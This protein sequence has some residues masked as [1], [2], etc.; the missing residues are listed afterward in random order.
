[1]IS[2][3]HIGRRRNFITCYGKWDF[4]IS[5]LQ[6]SSLRCIRRIC[7]FSVFFRWKFLIQR[8]DLFFSLDN[9]S[10]RPSRTDRFSVIGL[11]FIFGIIDFVIINCLVGS[12]FASGSYQTPSLLK[13]RILNIKLRIWRKITISIDTYRWRIHNNNRL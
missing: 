5:W 11:R 13:Q 6:F 1:M 2:I 10:L 8:L 4:W 3:Q 12:P 9:V 7:I